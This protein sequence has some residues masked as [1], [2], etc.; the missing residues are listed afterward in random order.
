[1]QGGAVK[2]AQLRRQS[3]KKELPVSAAAINPI[4]VATDM[5]TNQPYDKTPCRSAYGTDPALAPYCH[6]P[7][8]N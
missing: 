1:M 5:P 6:I 3:I 4:T 2:T 8:T 7:S